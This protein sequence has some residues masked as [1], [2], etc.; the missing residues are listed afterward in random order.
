MYKISKKNKFGNFGP[1][2]EYGPHRRNFT[3]FTFISEKKRY[4]RC[5][6]KIWG[7]FISFDMRKKGKFKIGHLGF[8][9]KKVNLKVLG[10]SPHVSNKVLQ[11]YLD[12]PIYYI[13]Q[14]WLWKKAI[15]MKKDQNDVFNI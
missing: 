3:I 15:I 4:F 5:S 12:P 2:I 9:K 7:N 14:K 10:M 6:Y 1:F 13:K 8:V 11:P